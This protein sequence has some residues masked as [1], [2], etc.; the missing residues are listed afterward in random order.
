MMSDLKLAQR[1]AT[2]IARAYDPFT[3]Y[4]LDNVSLLANKIGVRV[5]EH[6]NLSDNDIE[7]IKIFAGCHDIGKISIPEE[8][9]YKQEPITSLE[10]TVIET[11]PIIGKNIVDRVIGKVPE[12]RDA[13]GTDILYDIVYH[14]HERPNGTGYPEGLKGD[15]ISSAV[16]IVAVAD[17]Y[18]AMTSERA[19]REPLPQEKA[20]KIMKGMVDRGELDKV[21]FDALLDIVK[22]TE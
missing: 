16:R 1:L 19:Y 12:L 20:L 10:R 18:D 11:H 13:K 8:I 7:F 4:H 14:H 6:F 21:C 2:E 5:Q 3:A 9:L 15:E 17:C 22:E